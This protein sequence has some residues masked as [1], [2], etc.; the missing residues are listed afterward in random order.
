MIELWYPVNPL[1]INQKFGEN[2]LPF[3]KEIGLKGHNGID[4]YA[5]DGWLVRATHAGTITYAGE[6]GSGGLTVVIRTEETY[7]YKGEQVYFKTIYC[8]L[9]KGTFVVIAGQ[10]VLAGDVLAQADNTGMSTGSHLHFGL[11]P[12]AKGEADWQWFNFEQDNGY[13]GAIDPLP[14]FNGKY[15]EEAWNL[16]QQIS[17]LAKIVE[18]LQKLV[19]LSTGKS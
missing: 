19:G 9:K 16:R 14:Y 1:G 3:Y 7:E 17:V 13:L 12:V 18:A 15:A 5:P 10:K 11:K 4:F 6:D 8:H 2:S